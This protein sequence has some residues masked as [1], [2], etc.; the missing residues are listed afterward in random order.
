MVS[1][2]FTYLF[3]YNPPLSGSSLHIF[4]QAVQ[5]LHCHVKMAWGTGTHICVK[6]LVL[7]NWQGVR[8][9]Y[10]LTRSGIL[11]LGRFEIFVKHCIVKHNCQCSWESLFL[12]V[13]VCIPRLILCN[14]YYR[15]HIAPFQSTTMPTNCSHCLFLSLHIFVAAHHRSPCSPVEAALF[16]SV[17]FYYAD[18]FVPKQRRR[19]VLLMLLVS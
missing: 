7:G 18:S 8:W 1:L 4:P 15:D 6:Y 5:C 13:Q 11:K 17:L 2:L 12:S 19:N 14:V 16:P 9:D 10:F 3:L